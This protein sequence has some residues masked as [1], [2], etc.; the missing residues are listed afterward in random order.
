[1]PVLPYLS[2]VLRST[3]IHY[4]GNCHNTLDRSAPPVYI[5]T[6][7]GQHMWA[8]SQSNASRLKR[9]LAHRGSRPDISV[10]MDPLL[11]AEACT[12]RKR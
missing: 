6:R 2:V 11:K 3:S 4:V 8:S 10:M 7:S 1:M 12:P 9:A 5:Q